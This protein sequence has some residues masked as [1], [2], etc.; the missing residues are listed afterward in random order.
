MNLPKKVKI[1]EVC[2]R[3]GFQNVKTFIKT[4][5]KIAIIKKI[6]DSGFQKVEITSFVNPKRVP[7]MSD[8]KEVCKEVLKYAEGK[9]VD[10]VALVPNMKGAQLAFESNIKEINYVVS[11]SEKHNMANVQST[12]EES[13]LHFEEI[14]KEY[15]G[16]L[17]VRLALATTFGC[18]FGE[19][20]ETQKIITMAERG[21]KAGAS[22]I[23]LAD[24]VGLGNPVLVDSVLSEVKKYIP[25]DAISMHLHDTRG[26]ALANTLAALNYGVTEFESA[27]AGLGGCP[28]APGASGN[29]SSED[30]VNM[31]T[32]MGIETNINMDELKT[33]IAFIRERV[34]AP[35]IS[36]MAS[37]FAI[38]I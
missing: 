18:P 33:A 26:L 38:G 3:D 8:A 21:L 35:V 15:K 32:M 5:D 30:L 7:Q 24:T 23:L 4:E 16:A 34:N 2:G 37:L 10:L 28:F 1:V 17:K 19:K 22:K 6:I 27:A 9:G 12:V 36:H 31:L 29:V 11:V 25:V 14:C 20:I 13:L